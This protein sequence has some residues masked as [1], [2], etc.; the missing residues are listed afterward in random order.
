[1]SMVFTPFTFLARVAEN[2]FVH[3]GEI[4]GEIEIRLEIFANVIGVEHGV[5]GGL[6]DTW[7]VSQRVSQRAQQHAEISGEGAHASY[8]FRA[9]M[10]ECV[11]AVRLLTTTGTGRNG[12][13]IFFRKHGTAPGPPPPCGVEKVLCKFRCITSTPKSPGRV[14]PAS[15]F[16]LAP[17]M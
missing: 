13:R 8:G 15:A 1:M 5:F 10:I 11:G 6:A 14:T 3:R 12:S 17:S 2:D 16:M 9:I 4:I 7:S